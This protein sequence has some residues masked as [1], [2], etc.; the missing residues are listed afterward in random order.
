MDVVAAW[1]RH[2]TE[3]LGGQFVARFSRAMDEC[4]IAAAA[5]EDGRP[6]V[7]DLLR[8][9]GVMLSDFEEDVAEDGVA[10]QE[11]LASLPS[12]GSDKVK[13]HAPGTQGRL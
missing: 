4:G 7:R 5:G 3:P 8:E 12:E 9:A 13:K 1:L 2:A 6:L 10:Q 11:E